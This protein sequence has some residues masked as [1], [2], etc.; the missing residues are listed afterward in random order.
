M[1]I[2]DGCILQD[3]CDGNCGDTNPN[4]YAEQK[5]NDEYNSEQLHSCDWCKNDFLEDQLTDTNLGKLCDRCIQA[6]RSRG[7]RVEIIK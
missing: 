4:Y 6:I 2:C 1:N 7:E 3:R 5:E